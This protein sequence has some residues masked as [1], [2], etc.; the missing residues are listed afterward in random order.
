M[1]AMSCA[2]G[3][4]PL[5]APGRHRRPAPLAPVVPAR[6]YRRAVL[7]L[8]RPPGRGGGSGG[9][10]ALTPAGEKI[11]EDEDEDEDEDD[12]SSSESDGWYALS[13]DA[14]EEDDVDGDEDDE[15]EDG[16]GPAGTAPP[17]FDPFEDANV[18]DEADDDWPPPALPPVHP[19]GPPVMPAA[20]GGDVRAYVDALL[21]GASSGGGSGTPNPPPLA[22]IMGMFPWR[23]DPFQRRAIRASLAGRNVLVCAPTGAGKTAIAAA[24]A[25]GVLAAGKRVI[26]TTPLKALSNQK[27][28]EFR[29]AFGADRVGLQTGDATLNSEG[30]VVVMTTEVL[31]NIL[32]RVDGPA[33]EVE[34][35]GGDEG[36]ASSS[37]AQ[38]QQ[39]LS[40]LVPA[41]VADVG[42]IVLDEVHYLGDADRGTVWE[43]TIIGAPPGA[44]ILAMSATVRNPNDLGDW[45]SAVHGP[46]QTLRTADR[47]V[48]LNWL[49]AWG[50]PREAGRGGGGGWG[51]SPPPAWGRAGAAPGVGATVQELL[52][53]ADP[54]RPGRP[55][56]LA[57]ALRAPRPG[58]GGANGGPP[59]A[60]APP[61]PV[62]LAR[63]LD[64]RDLLPAIWF[65]FS[66]AGC[67]ATART[68]AAGRAVRPPSPE[69]AAAIDAALAALRADQPEAVREDMVPALEAGIA[70]HH[71]GCLPGWKGLVERL[72]QGGSL[73]LVVATE[74]LAAGI[75]MPAR[76]TIISALARRRGEQ[77]V[78]PLKHNE[79]LQMAG[80]AGRRGY[81]TVGHCVIAY[82]PSG[83][84]GGGS[85]GGGGGGGPGPAGA[86]S[87]LARGPERLASQFRP[88]Y[89]M[90]LN[91][92]A[93]RS[94]GDARAFV[95]RSF[96]AYL[97][98]E[99]ARR[100]AAQVA[101]AERAAD[102]L[103][104]VAEDAAA[105]AGEAV[106][107]AAAAAG[108]AALPSASAQKKEARRVLRS[109]ERG[110]VAAR[111]CRAVLTL[112]EDGT[113]LPR[114]ALL[115]LSGAVP[116]GGDAVP[117]LV[118]RF[119][120]IKADRA[121]VDASPD[122]DVPLPR[123]VLAG[124][125]A[126][127]VLCLLDDNRVVKARAAHLAAVAPDPPS[128]AWLAEHGGG[129]GDASALGDAVEEVASAAAGGGGWAALAGGCL[130][131]DG[132][133]G[134][135]A[136]AAGLAD[137]SVATP[138]LDLILPDAATELALD[139]ARAE[140]RACRAAAR[141]ESQAAR[142]EQRGRR[143]RK[144][145]HGR[146]GG[147]PPPGGPS[148]PEQVAAARLGAAAKEAA[149]EAKAARATA[150]AMRAALEDGAASSWRSFEAVAGVLAGAGAVE[151]ERD[152]ERARG[153]G[154]AGPT[155]TATAMRLL[156]LGE[157]ARSLHGEN[158]LWLACLLASPGV[159]A[160]APPE[161][162]GAVAGVL[163]GELGLRPGVRAR[164]PPSPPVVAAIAALDGTRASLARLQWRYGVDA[165]LAVDLRLSGVVQA[166]AS[167]LDWAAAVA[168]CALDPGDVARLMQRT[169]DL[170]RQ[171]AH[172]RALPP[173]LRDAARRAAR[174]CDRKP[175]ADM[176]VAE[177]R[178]NILRVVERGGEK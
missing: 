32:F 20:A 54:A 37:D 155:A 85:G 14:D 104:E 77:G 108:E 52:A 120:P 130:A 86:V 65:I 143:R 109:L 63:E 113:P 134:T 61:D 105:A 137:L 43:E 45:I 175:I 176:L 158:E 50:A 174:A 5:V 74:T 27:L 96:G 44:A 88:G 161:L 71:A 40:S 22:S 135:A 129:G 167:G 12:D 95:E 18:E 69:A 66:R 102:H 26:Y 93:T 119:T 117:A 35:E 107:A 4:R 41:R 147:P 75:N 53:P 106:A 64:G 177:E 178:R 55:G 100:R 97:G 103:E 8:A 82:G 115:D 139:A 38:K 48:P 127:E 79:L 70:S 1:M 84:G 67:D 6:P 9:G 60:F 15:D 133:G 142:E 17:T 144:P 124:E 122:G 80:R 156:P 101:A 73:K 81:D 72:F 21:A 160:L 126:G 19:G 159:Q 110:A 112:L 138:G 24:A 98:G 11:E 172:C 157:V 140:W 170:L 145:A 146:G 165:P 51:A 152:S 83:G 23:L 28:G 111:A 46:C 36:Q 78:A 31:R 16:D 114:V 118:V 76:T 131:A 91:L 56:R 39:P 30:G 34:E 59:P 2:L 49:Y 121:A 10:G 141:R 87:L 168:D 153:D 162:A 90:V 89:S 128:S 123:Q 171:A 42:L 3:G 58:G 68:L 169:V 99:G 116:D 173:G 125:P 33:E 29:A 92:V 149:R 151:G 94:L 62:A 150:R 164:Y 148:T 154:G 47:P 25:L 13:G 166:W 57:A 163:A 136:A 132:A 7:S